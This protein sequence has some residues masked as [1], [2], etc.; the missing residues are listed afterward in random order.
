MQV[1][2]RVL[3]KRIMVWTSVAII[4]LKVPDGCLCRE[5]NECCFVID[6]CMPFELCHASNVTYPAASIT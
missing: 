4:M 6:Y 5:N 3:N 2:K 1:V